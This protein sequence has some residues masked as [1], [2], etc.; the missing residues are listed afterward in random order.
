LEKEVAIDPE[1]LG[2]VFENLLESEARKMSGSFYTPRE[3][4]HYMVKESLIRFLDQTVNHQTAFQT[5]K[6]Q[7]SLFPS[8]KPSTLLDEPVRQH[9]E[10]IKLS[11]LSQWIHGGGE[12]AVKDY[13]PDQDTQMS[14]DIIK[15]AH[16]MDCAL[17]GLKICDPAI[18]SGA[19]PVALLLEVVR[20]RRSL[21]AKFMENPQ[22][23][24]ELKRETILNSIYGVDNEI[25][26]V[27]IA[28]LRLWL[29]LVVDEES[30][31]NI[32]PLPNLDYKIMVGNSLSPMPDGRNLFGQK[33]NE[34]YIKYFDTTDSKKKDEL[35][36]QI[37]QLA[38][39]NKDDDDFD[40]F[41]NFS[42]VF[43]GTNPGFDI[44]IGNPPYIQLQTM[45]EFADK[46]KKIGY[47]SYAR[48]GDIYCL[49]YEQGFRILAQHGILMFITSNKW[50]RTGYGE[51][52]RTFFANK[53]NPLRLIDFAGQKIFEAATVDVNILMFEKSS[54]SGQT[55]ACIIKDHK[56]LN[57][58][59][60]YIEHNSEGSR[61]DSSDSWTIL[62]PIEQSIKRKIEAVGIPLKNWDIQIYRGILTGCNEAFI[63]DG[64]KKDELIAA[65]PKS[66][67][68]LRP[69]LRGR[70]VKRYGYNFADQW[71][72]ATFPSRHY[73][74]DRY[75]S[76]KKHLL[77]F[78]KERLEQTG[79]TYYPGTE[80]EFK[81]R[82]KTNNKWFETQDSISY[83][84]DFSKQKIVWAETMRV[85]RYSF[86]RFPR[87][88]FV[89]KDIILDKTCFM[90]RG[91]NLKYII[92][93]LNSSTMSF[94]IHKNVSVLDSGGFLMQKIY[95]ENFPIP[96]IEEN[97]MHTI[98][99]IVDKINVER[100]NGNNGVSLEEELNRI[101]F[102]LFKLDNDEQSYINNETFK[103]YIRM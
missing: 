102:T 7:A 92:S 79:K 49:F 12:M 65:D 69:I 70:D 40:W 87:F 19:F 6:R 33:L 47:E 16:E 24:Y 43:Q 60:V 62:S 39:G 63:I 80:Q 17:A 89:K 81:A 86:D 94:Y 45:H 85:H 57:N 13:N 101:V 8:K 3:I 103:N 52:L 4:V 9:Q 78:G 66:A 1:M 18:G 100:C 26:A 68:I 31:D 25:S 98:S 32:K 99:M 46:L 44:V 74:I 93:I 34:L 84:E 15:L 83:W 5:L 30:F 42:R 41:F 71:L 59:S 82:K 64:T 37:S 28:K 58:L 2:Q 51:A 73:N 14:K 95:I 29:S 22:S 21:Q 56:C 27:D 36:H 23:A 75:P 10:R 11:D 20:L 54:N 72:I 50:M 67:E 76:I 90:L 88:S 96:Q 91:K 35:Q 55:Q 53:T 48:T 77:S 61:F 97:E 38:T